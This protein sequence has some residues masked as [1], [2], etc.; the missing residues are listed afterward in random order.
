MSKRPI[1]LNICRP[2]TVRGLAKAHITS[3]EPHPHLKAPFKSKTFKM[4]KFRGICI[5]LPRKSTY[6]SQP[7]RYLSP[8]KKRA[9]I[10]AS[11][12][13]P[14]PNSPRADF[15]HPEKWSPSAA[16]SAQ[17]RESHLFICSKYQCLFGQRFIGQYTYCRTLAPTIHLGKMENIF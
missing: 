3:N 2:F 8:A 7:K 10:I 9:G 11:T 17:Y 15:N 4:A 5:L 1:G 12:R 13:P 14:R 16:K 6:I